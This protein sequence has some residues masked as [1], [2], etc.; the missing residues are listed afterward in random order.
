MFI[1]LWDKHGIIH[2]L[3]GHVTDPPQPGG[4]CD[5]CGYWI[6][7]DT[8]LPTAIP[9][10]RPRH[11]RC[12]TKP[13]ACDLRAYLPGVFPQD[14]AVRVTWPAGHLHPAW[15]AA[16]HPGYSTYREDHHEGTLT[17]CSALVIAVTTLNVTVDDGHPDAPAVS[18]TLVRMATDSEVQALRRDEQATALQHTLA[19]RMRELMFALTAETPDTYSYL[20]DRARVDDLLGIYVPE[21]A[22]RPPA[23]QLEHRYPRIAPT[24]TNRI[25]RLDHQR[26]RVWLDTPGKPHLLHSYPAERPLREVVEALLPLSWYAPTGA[27]FSRDDVARLW[28]CSPRSV[29][30]VLRQ[31]GVAA[32]YRE[33]GAGA[34]FYR[35]DKVLN[36]R[37]QGVGRGSWQRRPRPTP[38]VPQTGETCESGS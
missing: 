6:Y 24:M 28:P 19:Q 22:D 36:A 3:G 37:R 32:A 21:L 11:R 7:P 27:H 38:N 10:Q 1:P 30:G 25:V 9:G 14:C 31:R 18:Y 8:G 12:P 13:P 23:G 35:A 20:A 29:R 4:I 17:T 5:R 34:S 15:E 16:W 33:S 26:N 2:V